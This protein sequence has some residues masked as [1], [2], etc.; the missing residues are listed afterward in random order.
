MI[1]IANDQFGVEVAEAVRSFCVDNSI[2]YS[3]SGSKSEDD[4]VT[5]QD[6]IPPFVHSVRDTP[7]ATGV[8]ICG[9]G[10][11]VEVGANK[12]R[13]IRASLCVT[14]QLAEWARVYDD[15]NVLCMPG[16]NT[17]SE[18]VLSIMSAWVSSRFDGD[19]GRT[20]MLATFDE[21]LGQ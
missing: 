17:S 4:F 3:V 12:F 2:E 20:K 5:L 9:T 14:P 16:W 13:G 18:Q 7:E 1:F 10:V 15:A 19:E 21:W 11:G 6:L 8:L